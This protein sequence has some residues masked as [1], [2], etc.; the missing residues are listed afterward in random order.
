MVQKE[1]KFSI[2]WRTNLPRPEI[3]CTMLGHKRQLL[4]AV[5]KQNGHYM[6]E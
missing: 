6:M 4:C 1:E 2:F 3:S 5:K